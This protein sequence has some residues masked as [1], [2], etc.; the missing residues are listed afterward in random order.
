MNIFLRN[1]LYALVFLTLLL[2]GDGKQHVSLVLVCG[3]IISLYFYT[4]HTTKKW[5]VLDKQVLIG[6][7][8]VFLSLFAS[9]VF[10]IGIGYSVSA[11][12]WYLCA[13][14]LFLYVSNNKSH[15]QIQAV[16][17][18][19][20]WMGCVVSAA[21]I[22]FLK[23]PGAK[24][25]L[26]GMNLLYKIYGHNHVV[27]LLFFSLPVSLYYLK[28]Y[29][30]LSALLGFCVIL[31]GFLTSFSRGALFMLFFYG[32]YYVL[33]QTRKNIR[34]K[35]ISAVGMVM[36][37]CVGVFLYSAEP[38]LI[39]NTPWTAVT[40]R[41]APIAESRLGY[42]KQVVN[43]VFARPFIGMGPGTFALLSKKYQQYPNTYSWFAHSFPMETIA[44]IGIIGFFSVAFVLCSLF[45]HVWKNISSQH[46]DSEL[47]WSLFTGVIVSLLYACFEMNLNFILIWL[48]FW[49]LIGVLYEQSAS[50]PAPIVV[51]NL[52]LY[53][54]LGVLFLYYFLYVIASL[55]QAFWHNPRYSWLFEPYNQSRAIIYSTLSKGK[56]VPSWP[57]Q[58]LLRLFHGKSG[59]VLQPLLQS[60]S[61]EFATQL[62]D[63]LRASDPQNTDYLDAYLRWAVQS[64]NSNALDVYIKSV[65]VPTLKKELVQQFFS[66]SLIDDIGI[67]AQP[68]EYNAKLL[69]LLGLRFLP[70]HPQ[71][72]HGLWKEAAKISPQWG[73]FHV[74]VASLEYHVLQ[75]ASAATNTI[76]SC[77]SFR[78]AAAQCKTIVLK[79]TQPGG[80][81]EN[82]KAIPSIR[83][84]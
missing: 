59:N 10:S 20:F 15:H 36:V 14:L 64:N 27:D 74:E 9:T 56:T 23:Y 3:G 24:D 62:Y 51:S 6:W 48:L 75:D 8:G 40:S 50:R 53:G 19:I 68:D 70:D 44:E 52:L 34:T 38:F 82:I 54:S 5:Y 17:N 65:G 4:R 49:G 7:A 29:R 11:I 26:P 63:N 60:N 41:R 66:K 16:S 28:K 83:S 84:N 31:L 77:Q 18:F 35:I 79:D 21:S 55:A 37:L 57:D 78:H 72:A 42:W 58:F 22:I 43:A 71:E 30:N 47:R 80:Q 46:Q 25:I 76:Q 13:F 61:P 67:P 69:Y 45:V 32:L 2:L 73:Y 81:F 12:V 1:I 33:F 39:K